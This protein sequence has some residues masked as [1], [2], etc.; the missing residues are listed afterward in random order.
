MEVL[1]DSLRGGRGQCRDH[2][3]EEEDEE[4]LIEE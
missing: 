2:D 4:D 3:V 1:E